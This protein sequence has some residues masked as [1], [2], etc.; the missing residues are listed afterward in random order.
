MINNL[1]ISFTDECHMALVLSERAHANI[2]MIDPSLAL[3]IPG[4]IGW[5]GYADM[6][7]Q[8][9][10]TPGAPAFNAPIFAETKV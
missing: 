7:A 5:I 6:P 3:N 2:L 10:N 9:S 1:K 4:V 8:C